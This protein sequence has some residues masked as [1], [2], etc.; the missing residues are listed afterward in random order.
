MVRIINRKLMLRLALHRLETRKKKLPAWQYE[1]QKRLI[2][3]IYSGSAY[4]ID[5]RLHRK[6]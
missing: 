2:R 5:L 6:I 3:K 1:Q 4:F